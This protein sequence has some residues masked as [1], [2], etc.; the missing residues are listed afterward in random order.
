M[1]E[2]KKRPGLKARALMATAI[3]ESGHVVAIWNEPALPAP[4]SVSIIPKGGTVGRVKFRL[5][6][7][8]WMTATVSSVRALIRTYLASRAAERLL[9]SSHTV[10]FYG[11]LEV[12]TQLALMVVCI[13]G[14]D[15]EFGLLFVPGSLLS[16]ATRKRADAAIRKVIAECEAQ[17]AIDMKKHEKQLRK[18]VPVLLKKKKLK[19]KQLKKILGAR[20][21]WKGNSLIKG[22]L[23]AKI[24][25][26]RARK[27]K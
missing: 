19:K 1:P 14:M 22:V 9:T 17:A 7:Q 4:R 15:Q 21:K 24:S 13:E 26:P 8:W 16:E 20:P 6:K 18:L 11:D 5:K 27:K 12:V 25:P 3:H 2:K 10:G 23:R